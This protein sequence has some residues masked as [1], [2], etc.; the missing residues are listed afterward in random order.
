MFLTVVWSILRVYF[1]GTLHIFVYPRCLRDRDHSGRSSSTFRHQY[2]HKR[3]IF[4]Y[5][6]NVF[7]WG[8]E[9]ECKV[10]SVGARW[11]GMERFHSSDMH[12]MPVFGLNKNEKWNNLYFVLFWNCTM[13]TEHPKHIFFLQIKMTEAKTTTNVLPTL[14]IQSR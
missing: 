12:S 5:I 8:Y 4:S 11:N 7:G 10:C 13:I 3:D 9:V 14:Q 6:K 2:H 1:S